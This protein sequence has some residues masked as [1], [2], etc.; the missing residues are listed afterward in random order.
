MLFEAFIAPIPNFREIRSGRQ[1]FLQIRKVPKRQL[2]F[3]IC[4]CQYELGT[5]H[6]QFVAWLPSDSVSTTIIQYPPNDLLS[7]LADFLN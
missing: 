2:V 4:H 7:F 5:R 6:N 3:R 1:V